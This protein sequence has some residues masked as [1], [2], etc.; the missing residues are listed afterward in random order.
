MA[1]KSANVIA[2]V[3]PDVKAK[4]ESILQGIGVPVSTLIN[5]L[6]RQ[7]I[8]ANG[9]PFSLSIPKG[10]QSL[11]SMSENEFNEMLE[12]SLSQA[13]RGEGKPVDQVFASIRQRHK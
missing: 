7:I 4:A 11:D 8:Y 3:E 9:I 2:R 10:V 12:T 13:A 5:A 1:N 6:Y